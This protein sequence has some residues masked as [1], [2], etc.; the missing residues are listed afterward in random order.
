MLAPLRDYL[1]PKD[2]ASSP[3]LATTK[4]CYFTRFLPNIHP[5]DPSF[6]ESQWITSEDLNVEHLLDI[7]TSI[8][9][10]SKGVWDACAKFM[11]H[12]YWHKPRLVVLG[13]KD[14]GAP[15]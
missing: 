10:D 7:F 13:A 9:T 15:G 6:E 4:E 12:L 14:R 11:N 5:N 2:P 8:H 1:R 3:L